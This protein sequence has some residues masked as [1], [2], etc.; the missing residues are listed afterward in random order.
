[1]RH[2]V[3]ARPV[4]V[5][6]DRL[7]YDRSRDDQRKSKRERAAGMRARLDVDIATML[8]GQ[9]AREVEAEAG[10]ADLAGVP[11]LDPLEAIEQAGHLLASDADAV[12]DHPKYRN[13]IRRR[14]DT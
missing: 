11:V 7:A 8:A 9:L 2:E 13:R 10:A 12:I 5:R 6:S 3:A 14:D 1:P 4:R